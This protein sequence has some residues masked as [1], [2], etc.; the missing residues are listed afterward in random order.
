MADNKEPDEFEQP[1]PSTGGGGLE[2]LANLGTAFGLGAT[3]QITG[4]DNLG[5]FVDELAKRRRSI[6]GSK[7]NAV[8]LSNALKTGN[9][10]KKMVPDQKTFDSLVAMDAK[11]LNTWMAQSERAHI[12]ELSESQ[13]AEKNLAAAQKEARQLGLSLVEDESL[14][15]LQERIGNQYAKERAEKQ[16]IGTANNESEA[17]ALSVVEFNQAPTARGLEQIQDEYQAATER[18][19]SLEAAGNISEDFAELQRRLLRAELSNV[20]NGANRLATD[21]WAAKAEQGNLEEA[22]KA[23]HDPSAPVMLRDSIQRDGVYTNM[24]DRG[25]SLLSHFRSLPSNVELSPEARRLRDLLTGEESASSWTALAHTNPGLAA[26]L[27]RQNPEPLI[28]ELSRATAEVNILEPAVESLRTSLAEMP[29]GHLLFPNGVPEDLSEFVALER[30]PDGTGWQLSQSVPSPF[31]HFI[32]NLHTMDGQ[33]V[34]KLRQILTTGA[35]ATSPLLNEVRPA[36]EAR[37][38]EVVENNVLSPAAFRETIGDANSEVLSFAANYIVGAYVERFE[39]WN[40]DVSHHRRQRPFDDWAGRDHF[41]EQVASWWNPTREQQDTAVQAVGGLSVER[42]DDLEEIR[43]RGNL[44]AA[45]YRRDTLVMRDRIGD[46]MT[47]VLGHVASLDYETLGLRLDTMVG[48]VT[49]PLN[50]DALPVPSTVYEAKLAEIAAIEDAYRR[51][52][53]VMELVYDAMPLLLKDSSAPDMPITQGD[54]DMAKHVLDTYLDSVDTLRERSGDLNVGRYRKAG[55]VGAREV[56]RRSS[57]D[58]VALSIMLEMG[59]R[60]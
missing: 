51:E 17:F 42:T 22:I 35:G 58:M 26:E 8:L 2:A 40:E 18:I 48:P 25:E 33:D 52:D 29:G 57:L 23:A 14:V 45:Q 27:S 49:D 15:D 44:H 43:R 5:R 50:P 10:D 47:E 28:Q 53:A 12:R 34:L 19:D 6:E 30:T 32:Q 3:D 9:I 39:N 13:S 60:R 36:V 21:K 20:E 37:A 7:A 4:R 56:N 55:N 38:K 31:G 59:T 54:I 1:S 11:D 16:A 41:N 46:T 24:K